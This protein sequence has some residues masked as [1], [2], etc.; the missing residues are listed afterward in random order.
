MQEENIAMPTVCKLR[1][2]ALIIVKQASFCTARTQQL[3]HTGSKAHNHTTQADYP[4]ES[5]NDS[6]VDV[7]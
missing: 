6:L 7:T 2:A 4:A 5:L 3:L 1:T